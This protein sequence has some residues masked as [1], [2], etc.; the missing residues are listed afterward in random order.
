MTNEQ[1]VKAYSMLLEGYTLSKVAAEFGVTRQ[2]IH[3]LFPV[4]SM[5]LDQAAASCIYPNISKWM[6]ANNVGYTYIAKEIGTCA[7]RVR[8]FLAEGS[9]SRK[10]LI[11]GILS[12]TGLT[13]EE[14][15]QEE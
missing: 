9:D 13:Y 5:R 6:A 1:K 14:A 12:V 8:V 15:F 7:Q 3:Q 11:D 2:R 10:S 4:K